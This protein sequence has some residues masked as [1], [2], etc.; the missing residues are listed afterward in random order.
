M[1]VTAVGCLLLGAVIG[2]KFNLKMIAQAVAVVVA[3]WVIAAA[4]GKVSISAALIGG[5]LN[6]VALQ[7]GYFVSLIMSAM[8]LTADHTV[9]APRPATTNKSID[10]A[11]ELHKHS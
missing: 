8:G 5:F 11:S 10:A 2:L 6:A 9:T 4:I 7:A 1:L 3:G